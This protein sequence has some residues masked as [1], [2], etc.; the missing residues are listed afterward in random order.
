MITNLDFLR[1]GQHWP[2]ATEINRLEKYYTNK[3][4]F[5]GEH[6]LVYK[7][8]FKR[9]ARHIG[10]FE[11]IVSYSVICNF[12]KLISLKIA[13]FML[14]EEPTISCSD[15]NSK[16]Q[17][18]IDKIKENN[19]LINTCYSLAID[20]SRYGDAVFNIYKD[21][22]EGKGII[23]ITQPSFYFKV[24]DAQNIKKVQYHVLAHKYKKLKPNTLFNTLFN[25]ENQYDDFLY[26]EIHSKGA[27]EKITYKLNKQGY[28]ESVVEQ[29]G[30]IET[31]LD[32]F[33]IVP[34][35]NLLTSDRVYGIDDYSDIDSIISELEVRIS[36][37]A[38]ILDKHAEPSM[39]GP[40]TALQYNKATGR[41]ELKVGNYFPKS[42]KEDA[43][44][45]YITWEAQLEA[46]FKQIEKL[47]NILAVI[48]EMG[49]AIFDFDNKLGTAASGTALKRMMI[50]PL[51]KVNRVRMS[52][53][54][55]LKKA[56]KLCSQLGGENIV[57]LSKEKINIFWND[58]LPND[59]L[60]EANIMNIRTGG[61]ATISQYSA[62]KRLDNLSDEDTQAE[63]EAIQGEESTSNPLNNLNM[64]NDLDG[65]NKNNEEVEE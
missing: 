8:N 54:S 50:S 62:I 36:Q 22:D 31:G 17:I 45:S 24:V 51:A 57:D 27:Y 26:V 47:I 23:D 3:R 59:D 55:A 13:D 14:G 56:I 7:E 48:S 37:I 41:Y 40:E 10:N 33:A 4:I 21:L 30:P 5:E 20:L 29:T 18:A 38:K 63:L 53:D 60:E 9:I 16:Q 46:S 12:Q 15:D 11:D 19:D 32:D 28:I 2:P 43:D 49:S 6:E 34:V 65:E 25:D 1:I 44:V 58:G 35:H 52:V 61:K 64:F 42:S 39:Q